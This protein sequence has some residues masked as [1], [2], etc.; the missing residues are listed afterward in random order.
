VPGRP[1]VLVIGDLAGLDDL[2]MLSPV[3]MQQAKPAA[4]VIEALIAGRAPEQFQYHDPG[5]MATIGRNSAVAEL[6]RFRFTG[7]PG[8]VFWLVVHLAKMVTF[9]ARV[10]TLLAWAYDYIFLDRPVR[11]MVKADDPPRER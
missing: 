9:R 8:W 6:G 11:I 4:H 5:T 3:A 1:E 2:P 7:F 10:A